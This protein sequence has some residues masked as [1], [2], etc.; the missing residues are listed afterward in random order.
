MELVGAGAARLVEAVDWLP[1]RGNS[2]AVYFH[3]RLAGQ[4]SD[5]QVAAQVVVVAVLL[6]AALHVVGLVSAEASAVLLVVVT[7][8]ETSAE[9]VLVVEG[10]VVASAAFAVVIRRAKLV[11]TPPPQLAYSVE[12]HRSE[13]GSPVVVAALLLP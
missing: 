11:L 8:A 13:E 3:F 2:L 9:A 5:L 10:R 6:V 7:S 4:P 1:P 12:L